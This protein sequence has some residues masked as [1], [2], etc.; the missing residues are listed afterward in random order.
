MEGKL[1]NTMH[2]SF[3]GFTGMTPVWFRFD[4]CCRFFIFQFLFTTHRGRVEQSQG[5]VKQNQFNHGFLSALS[6]NFSNAIFS[7]ATGNNFC[8][9]SIH[10][11]QRSDFV[12]LWGCFSLTTEYN[13]KE[14]FYLKSAKEKSICCCHFFF[15]GW[16]EF[17]QKLC[18]Y[19]LWLLSFKRKSLS[20]NIYTHF[21][22]SEV[23]R[24]KSTYLVSWL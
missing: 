15:S 9:I 10:C 13:I 21:R 22:H 17:L 14:S 2:V 6:W 12:N 24:Y 20:V 4:C 19:L 18:S 3:F 8:V 7:N 16:D 5:K 1:F 11:H 23:E